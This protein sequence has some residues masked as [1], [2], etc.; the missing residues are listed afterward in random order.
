MRTAKVHRSKRLKVDALPLEDC[1]RLMTPT[2]KTPKVR[3]VEEQFRRDL[4]RDDVVDLGRRF[5]AVDVGTYRTNGSVGEDGGS[6]SPPIFR[7]QS[8]VQVG[9]G[10]S[11]LPS[12]GGRTIGAESTDAIGGRVLPSGLG[13][14]PR[15][16]A[17]MFPDVG[18]WVHLGR[19]TDEGRTAGAVVPLESRLGETRR[20]STRSSV[21]STRKPPSNFSTWRR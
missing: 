2:A 7:L 17:V 5:D 10:W 20:R 4:S 1:F 12:K 11:A 18:H 3:A 14:F 15:T 6:G 19:V 8:W 9:A 16:A 13:Y 21:M